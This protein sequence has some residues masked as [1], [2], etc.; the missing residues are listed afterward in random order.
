M[1][2]RKKGPNFKH[3][4]VTSAV[5]DVAADRRQAFQTDDP[6]ELDGL[7][8]RTLDI[9]YAVIAPRISCR[10]ENE[11]FLPLPVASSDTFAT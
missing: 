6:D 8:Y 10:L 9:A 5:V 1:D 2:E 3:V 7:G 4:F 11:A